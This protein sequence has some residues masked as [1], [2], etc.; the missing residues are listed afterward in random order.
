MAVGPTVGGAFFWR[1][2]VA[3]FA[4]NTFSCARTIAGLQK[5]DIVTEIT[6]EY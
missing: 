6:S 5:G 4:G 2:V 1:D 3:P